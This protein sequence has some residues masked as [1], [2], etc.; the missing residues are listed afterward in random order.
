[1]EVKAVNN[2]QNFT[3][4][5]ACING[6]WRNLVRGGKKV[7][8]KAVKQNVETHSLDGFLKSYE[9]NKKGEIK[10]GE[11]VLKN[12]P[13]FKP[14]YY[15]NHSFYRFCNDIVSNVYVRFHKIAMG[16]KPQD[17]PVYMI[18]TGKE[19]VQDYSLKTNQE[20]GM[21]IRKLLKKGN[22]SLEDR[23]KIS[24]NF[25]DKIEPDKEYMKK[26]GLAWID[27]SRANFVIKEAKR[28]AGI[29]KELTAKEL[30][31]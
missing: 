23:N 19:A 27:A 20:R 2:K 29:D 22:I 11:D 7:S 10:Y 13:S 16:E 25:T 18:L 5:Y 8:V 28:D 6:E 14:N 1:M 30:I 26:H 17:G 21:F 3:S 24:Y 12:N 9:K 31:L 15:K 4:A